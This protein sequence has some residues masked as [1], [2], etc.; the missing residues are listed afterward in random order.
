MSPFEKFVFGS[1]I[2]SPTPRQASAVR[3]RLNPD[4]A[5]NA[6]PTERPPAAFPELAVHNGRT[7]RTGLLRCA[8]M[9]NRL[10]PEAVDHLWT[11][12]SAVLSCRRSLPCRQDPVLLLRPVRGCTPQPPAPGR[13]VLHVAPIICPDK[14]LPY[15]CRFS[16][17]PYDSCIYMISNSAYF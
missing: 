4:S 16:A 9:Q 15:A 5:G 7:S 3:A 14:L 10:I 12:T 17:F 8:P 1:K 11:S 2:K 6:A 13:P